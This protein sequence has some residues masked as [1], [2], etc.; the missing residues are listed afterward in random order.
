MKAVIL[1]QDN[2]FDLADLA[3]PSPRAGEVLIRVEACSICASDLHVAAI[4]SASEFRYPLVGGHEIAGQVVELGSG[5][6]DF[7]LSERVVVDP[8]TPCGR[9]APCRAGHR[10]L[11]EAPQIIGLQQPGGFA[12]Y[13]VAPAANLL[14]A[15]DLPAPVAALTEPL[16]CTLHGLSRLNPGLADNVLI[17]GVG[18]MGLLFLQL[19]RRACAGE[20]AAVDV[21]PYRLELARQLGADHAIASGENLDSQLAQISARGFDNVI[22]VTGAPAAVEDAFRRVAPAGRLLMLG[23]CPAAAS[24]AIS[25]RQVQRREMT[26]LGSFGFGNQFANALRVL[27][28]GDIRSDL[29]LTHEYPL[30][31]HVE[32]FEQARRGEQAVKVAFVP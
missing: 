19:V 15:G 3:V 30:E 8:V 23:S 12:E 18:A 2:R 7:R 27:Q 29:I 21:Q 16:A 6:S 9:C 10:N 1:D 11:C 17:Y 25:P 14:P 22:D 31:A 5:V 4:K 24:I 13:V 32:A 26:V 20:I 28:R